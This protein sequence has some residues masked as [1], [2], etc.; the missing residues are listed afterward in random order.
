M[1]LVWCYQC[2]LHKEIVC[3][4]FPPAFGCTFSCEKLWFLSQNKLFHFHNCKCPYQRFFCPFVFSCV[5]PNR[6]TKMYINYYRYKIIMRNIFMANEKLMLVY[7]K[8]TYVVLLLLLGFFR[9]GRYVNVV[10][11]SISHPRKSDTK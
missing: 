7:L 11:C 8:I 10:Q 2:V 5:L 3:I 1:P 6:S 9:E 4:H